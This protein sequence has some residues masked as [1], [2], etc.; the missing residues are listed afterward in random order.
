MSLNLR[1]TSTSL[2]FVILPPLQIN[3]P[4]W[5]RFLHDNDVKNANSKT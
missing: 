2:L 3:K 5:E 4:A 1:I